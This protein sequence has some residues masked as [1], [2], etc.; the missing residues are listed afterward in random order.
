MAALNG[1]CT[2]DFHIAY[3]I[4]T[5]VNNVFVVYFDKRCI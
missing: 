3:F 4:L 2:F 5:D 1:M